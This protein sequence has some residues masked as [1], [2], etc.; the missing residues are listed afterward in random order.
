LRSGARQQRE[1]FQKNSIG[2]DAVQFAALHVLAMLM[3]Q[4]FIHVLMPYSSKLESIGKWYRQ[5]WAESLGKKFDIFGKV[6]HT[7]P[8]PIAALGATD[9]HSQIQLY[10]EGPQDKVIT[11]IEISHFQTKQKLPKA[12]RA[13]PALSFLAGRDL[14]EVIHAER[15]ATAKALSEAERPNGTILLGE[16]NPASIG[17]LILFFEIA[18]GIAGDLLDVNPY[19]QPGVEAG[20]KAMYAILQS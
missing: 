19:D 7:G 11:F 2:G 14:S 4:R 6:Q 9:Q 15:L 16:I 8:T 5:L 13:F 10:M 20:K 12:I 17:A 18:T 1:A 3:Q